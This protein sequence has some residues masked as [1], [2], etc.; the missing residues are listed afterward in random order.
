MPAA[1]ILS[2]NNIPAKVKVNQV[3]PDLMACA[4]ENPKHACVG[5]MVGDAQ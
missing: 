4:K 5:M 3:T 2:E 1:E